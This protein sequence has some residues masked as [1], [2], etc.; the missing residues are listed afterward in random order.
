MILLVTVTAGLDIVDVRPGILTVLSLPPV[1]VVRVLVTTLETVLPGL[2]TILVVVR[3][4][5]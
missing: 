1:V 5:P 4:C 2:D 3:A